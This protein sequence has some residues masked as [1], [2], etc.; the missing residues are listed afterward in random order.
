MREWLWERKRDETYNPNIRQMPT[1]VGVWWAFAKKSLIL[2]SAPGHFAHES[3]RSNQLV[4]T[5]YDR[6]YPESV[7]ELRGHSRL[8]TLAQISLL[9][10][11]SSLQIKPVSFLNVISLVPGKLYILP[12]D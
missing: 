5:E 4:G 3:A 7:Y 6:Q 8:P 2:L 1:P 12:A 9:D 11:F 10:D